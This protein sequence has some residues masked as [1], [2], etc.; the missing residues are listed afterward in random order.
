LTSSCPSMKIGTDPADLSIV[1]YVDTVRRWRIR[2]PPSSLVFGMSLLRWQ[3]LQDTY[4]SDVVKVFVKE[5]CSLKEGLATEL[6]LSKLGKLELTWWGNAYIDRIY[7][8][9]HGHRMSKIKEKCWK[10]RIWKREYFCTFN[11]LVA[12]QYNYSTSDHAQL[13]ASSITPFVLVNR[14]SG[15][16]R[17]S[18]D[19]PTWLTDRGQ[20]RNWAGR[21]KKDSA[22]FSMM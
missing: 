6:P 7:T 15:H 5:K 22:Y 9:S 2:S 17:L 14:M 4:R 10:E 11:F 13:K 21:L 19:P 20:N 1:L 16:A 3:L 8:W 18:P 12:F